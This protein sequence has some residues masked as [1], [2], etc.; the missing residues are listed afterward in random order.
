LLISVG[1]LTNLVQ[2]TAHRLEPAHQ[3]IRDEIRASR[4]V[5]SDETGARVDGRNQWQ[6]VFVTDTATY[7]L[8]SAS[9][10]SGI[11][12]T[13]MAE[14]VPLVWVSDLFSAQ[15]KAKSTYR[16]ICLAHQVRDLQYAIDAE[17]SAW[18]YRL[19]Q[20]FLRAQRLAKLRQHL[21]AH[22]YHQAVAHV[23][24]ETDTLLAVSLNT[25][26][27]QRLQRRYLKHRASLFVF[28][29]QL[30]VPPDNN[31]SERALRNS[32]IHR[33]VSGGFRFVAGA[34]AHAI[35][36]SVADTARKRDQDILAVL[37]DLTGQ[38]A[39]TSL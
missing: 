16:Q 34:Q 8:I 31:A 10:G 5:Q 11:I 36:S 27:T 35:V 9:R 38:P 15:G 1:G 21:P 7:H 12:Q 3:T 24:T 2:R 4:V 32:V 17:R 23:E 26:D 37:Q 25:P 29:H 28:L 22:L 20:L 33:K 18:A 39:P 19:Q 14:A 13:V 30:H 6:W